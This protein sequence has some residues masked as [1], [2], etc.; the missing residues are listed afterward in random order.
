MCGICGE[1]RFGAGAP[2]IGDELVGMR[3][4]LLHRGPD[5]DGTYVSPDG[6]SATLPSGDG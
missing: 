3:D 4:L 1:L 5:S 6:S 2:P